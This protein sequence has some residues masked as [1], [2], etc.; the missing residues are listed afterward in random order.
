MQD[1]YAVLRNAAWLV[2]NSRH[3]QMN[4]PLALRVVVA[5]AGRLMAEGEPLPDV[6]EALCELLIHP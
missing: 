1:R 5:E 3:G 6:I 4:N 2:R